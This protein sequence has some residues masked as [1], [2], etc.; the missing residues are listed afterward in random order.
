MSAIWSPS[1]FE[2]LEMET[3]NKYPKMPW[4]LRLKTFRRPYRRFTTSMEGMEGFFYCEFIL[5]EYK[6][7]EYVVS[8]KR[9]V[10]WKWSGPVNE[11]T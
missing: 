6:D 2:L 11:P 8:I 10:E 4:F 3:L 5:R 9:R 7:T 1:P